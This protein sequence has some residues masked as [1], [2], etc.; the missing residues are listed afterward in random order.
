MISAGVRRFDHVGII[1]DDIDAATDFFLELGFE[2]DGKGEVEGEWVGKVIGLGDVK[3]EL[4]M[5]SPPGGGTKL[6]LVKFLRPEAEKG[7]RPA[8]SNRLGIRHISFAVNDLDSCIGML[9]EKGYDLVGEVV[10]YNDV[11]RVCYVHGPEGI[12]VELAEEIG[13]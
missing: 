12:I 5:L 1:L 6:E 10:N 11:V 9:R 2:L 13:E 8:P 7:D 3:S 4:V